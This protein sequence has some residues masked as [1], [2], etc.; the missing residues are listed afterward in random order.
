MV[1]VIEERD[2][3][4]R[5]SWQG[6]TDAMR[7][8]HLLQ[9][10]EV[11]DTFLGEP[12]RTLLNRSAYQQEL[13]FG[14]KAVTV[15]PEN[16]KRQLPSIHGAMILFD[17][18][19]GSVD[20]V[21]ESNLV[22]RWKTAGDSVLAS[23]YLAR[24]DSRNL[25]IMGGGTVANS[26]A[27]A[28]QSIFPD[29]ERIFVWTRSPAAGRDFADQL[30]KEGIRVE[31]VEHLEQAVVEADIIS[32]ATMAKE[33]I[34]AGAWVRSGTHV[35]LIGAFKAD[36]READDALLLKSS[37]FLDSRDTVL[38]HIGELKI[39]L[40]EGVITRDHIL[41]DMYELVAGQVGRKSADEITLFKNGGGAHLDLMTAR[42]IYQSC[43]GEP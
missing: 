33:P 42:Y 22:T 15:Y 37:I 8:G 41:G 38:D 19:T 10:A 14:V 12:D 26:L 40:G 28:Y 7:A 5:L 31:P 29:L 30:D 3:Q 39:P 20:A 2:A 11:E 1:T 9:T 21:V 6:V 13:G 43:V 35:D 17:P 25:L 18:E 16:S 4:G 27:H 34:L 32:S 24:P 36:M 23:R